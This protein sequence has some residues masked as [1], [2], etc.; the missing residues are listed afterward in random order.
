MAR[1]ILLSSRR[2]G[3]RSERVQR[4]LHSATKYRGELL[5]WYPRFRRVSS[6]SLGKDCVPQTN[7]S[8]CT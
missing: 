2:Q 5:P 3:D 6:I 1:S 7:R 4:F 8:G